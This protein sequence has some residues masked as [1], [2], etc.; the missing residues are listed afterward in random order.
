MLHK[1][2]E[3]EWFLLLICSDVAKEF[4]ST[5]IPNCNVSTASPFEE[6][7]CFFVFVID[8]T[9][10]AA[11]ELHLDSFSQWSSYYHFLM[12]HVIHSFVHSIKSLKTMWVIRFFFRRTVNAYKNILYQLKYTFYS[13]GQE[14]LGELWKNKNHWKKNCYAFDVLTIRFIHRSLIRW[15]RIKCICWG[16][17]HMKSLWFD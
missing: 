1:I 15:F 6:N 4:V 10:S 16:P 2:N 17:K 7:N 8:W 3:S 14:I 12:Y 5:I 13:H 11:M 9:I